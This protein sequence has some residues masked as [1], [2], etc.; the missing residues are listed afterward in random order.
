M[1]LCVVLFLFVSNIR[2][3]FF[4]LFRRENPYSFLVPG[5]IDLIDLKTYEENYREETEIK[6]WEFDSFSENNNIFLPIWLLL[7]SC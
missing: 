1:N 5:F 2:N 7:R 6:Y 4:Q 3:E